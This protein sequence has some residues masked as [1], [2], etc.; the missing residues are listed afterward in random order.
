MNL[1]DLYQ[2]ILHQDI[3]N[4]EEISFLFGNGICDSGGTLNTPEK[5]ALFLL[6]YRNP[7]FQTGYFQ[8]LGTPEEEFISTNLSG[9]EMDSFYLTLGRSLSKKR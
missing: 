2:E 1:Q 7:E 8:N 6:G 3:Q 4:V 9:D 5:R